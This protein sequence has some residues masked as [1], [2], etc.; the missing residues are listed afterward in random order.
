VDQNDIYIHN[1]SG[2]IESAAQGVV[3]DFYLSDV[4]PNSTSSTFIAK[5]SRY[6][7]IWICYCSTSNTTD[8]K[9]D[10]ALV[11]NYVDNTWTIRDLPHVTSM[12][13]S[14]GLS[15]SSWIYGR[16]RLLAT[17]GTNNLFLMDSTYQMYNTS[18]GQYS[19]F[20]SWVERVKLFADD[21]FSNQAISG[22]API[23][24]VSESSSEINFF[25]HSQNTYDK[26]PDWSNSSGRDVFVL[27]PK[28]ETQ[29]YKVDPRSVGRFLNYR[30]ISNSYWKMSF[31]GL[32]MTAANRR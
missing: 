1:G 29:G 5:D 22:L 13:T 16:E 23:I 12:F 28:D 26:E 17:S 32:D 3:R 6:K 7:E 4:N 21:P 11:F 24:E 10:R 8:S 19:E 15:G 18:A 20:E 27:R 14:P 2:N 31:L 9:C 25:V 30:V